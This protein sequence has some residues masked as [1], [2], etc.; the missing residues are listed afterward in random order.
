MLQPLRHGLFNWYWIGQTLSAVGDGIFF[1]TLSILILQRRDNPADLGLVL[2]AQSLAFAVSVLAG[3]VVA[4]RF[5]RSNVIAAADLIRLV[6]VAGFMLPLIQAHLGLLVLCGVL[7]GC[8]QALFAP[9]QRALIPALV[10]NEVIQPAN[11]L[12]TTS[13]RTAGIV[14][15]AIGG[16]VVTALSV[17]WAFAI[18]LATFAVSVVT[19]LVV[20]RN[21]SSDTRSRPS[22]SF[23]D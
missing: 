19:L 6:A 22:T 17:E 9:A 20:S 23:V 18:D 15:P 4:D 13:S 8:G 14:G 12:I 11:A 5:K 7:M 21:L 10:P 1:A 2:G 3:G 16:V